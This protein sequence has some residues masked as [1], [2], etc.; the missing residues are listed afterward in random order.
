M[1][2]LLL[3]QLLFFLSSSGILLLAG[4]LGILLLFLLFGGDSESI[5]IRFSLIPAVSLFVEV[6][7]TDW[8][9]T[10]LQ[11]LSLIDCPNKASHMGNQEL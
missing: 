10:V 1:P 7:Q 6:R 8:L 9:P 5:N 11:N 4:L 2:G 3:W